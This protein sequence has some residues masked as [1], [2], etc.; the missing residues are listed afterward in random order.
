MGQLRVRTP[1]RSLRA[2]LWHYAAVR[3]VDHQGLLMNQVAIAYSYAALTAMSGETIRTV[4]Q[5]V[6]NNLFNPD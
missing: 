3:P 4:V 2:A 1:R 6:C 5:A